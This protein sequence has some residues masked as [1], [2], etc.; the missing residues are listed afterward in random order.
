MNETRIFDVEI[1]KLEGVCESELFKKMVKNGDITASKVQDMLNEV[2][3]IN[4]YAECHIKTNDKEF[5]L[6][7]FST[8]KGFISTGS[9]VLLKSVKTYFNDIKLFKIV[10]I[11]TRKGTT[12]KVSPILSEENE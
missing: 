1:K 10:S 7:Y 5:D 4:G 6:N 9:E 2:V 8:N 12:Y 11:K 3:E